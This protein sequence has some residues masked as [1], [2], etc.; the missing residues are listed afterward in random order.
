MAEGTYATGEHP[1]FSIRLIGGI[2]VSCIT[3]ITS[4]CL[5]II[6]TSSLEKDRFH[7]CPAG[8]RLSLHLFVRVVKRDLVER[9]SASSQKSTAMPCDRCLCGAW[10]VRPKHSLDS[11]LAC[12]KGAKVVS[13]A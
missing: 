4:L 10:I 1:F 12:I 7:I 2:Y 13:L 9:F 11:S 8:I 5:L 6:Q 3:Q